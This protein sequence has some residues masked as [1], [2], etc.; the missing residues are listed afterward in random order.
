M[1]VVLQA[2]RNQGLRELQQ[3]HQRL[4]DVQ[5]QLAFQQVPLLVSDQHLHVE[6]EP[7]GGALNAVDRR[8]DLQPSVYI[9]CLFVSMGA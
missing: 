8:C 4:K 6:N 5:R 9:T 3:C 2:R 1:Q 7:A